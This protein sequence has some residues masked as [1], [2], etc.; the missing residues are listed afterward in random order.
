MKG[1]LKL[2]IFAYLGWGCSPDAKISIA[3]NPE[4]ESDLKDGRLLLIFSKDSTPEPRFGISDQVN[5][6]QVFGMDF[7][8]FEPGKTLVLE[9]KTFGYP[10]ENLHDIPDGTYY[11]QAFV[12]KHETFTRADGH[13]VK[14][15]MDQGEGRQWARAPKNI[16]STP[17]RIYWKKGQNL[18]LQID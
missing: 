8:N 4:L 11:V 15:P 7:E 2:L 18:N 16:Y 12:Q 5:S 6:N 13:T 1:F 9:P 14:L 17:Q 10:I 3:I